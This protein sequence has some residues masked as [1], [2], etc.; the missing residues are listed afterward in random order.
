M[1]ATATAPVSKP[2]G[3]AGPAPQPFK[4]PP[5]VVWQEPDWHRLPAYKD[6]SAA[7]KLAFARL[8]IA[9]NKA[10]DAKTGKV[11]KDGQQY[12]DQ[13]DAAWT[14]YLKLAPS[15][16]DAKTAYQF[17]N[18][19]LTQGAVDYAKAARALQAVL[20]TRPPS[21][22]L[23]AQLALYNLAAGNTSDYKEA[24]AKAISLAD[25]KQRKDAIAK[26]LDQYEKE[27]ADAIKAQQKQQQAQSGGTTGSTTPPL[28]TLPSLGGVSSGGGLNTAGGGPLG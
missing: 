18:F 21:A 25:S 4:Y 28:K 24:R 15:K 16:P 7:D 19:Y 22:G 3:R 20:V 13:A 2:A 17:V 10:W 8:T 27:V 5:D 26:Q 23:Y 1:E 6:V 11:A 9:A 12:I 14:A